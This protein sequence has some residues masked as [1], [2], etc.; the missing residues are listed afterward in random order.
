[1]PRQ[2]DFQALFE[3]LK[4]ILEPYA[5]HL[6]VKSDQPGEYALYTHHKR[7]DGYQFAFGSVQVKKNYVS[8]HLIPLYNHPELLEKISPALRK[9]MQGKSCFNF[10]AADPALL[11]ELSQLTQR[12]FE[13][14]KATGWVS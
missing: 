12:G 2:S 7:P 5:P 14:F 9:R 11:E 1:M 6:E 8:Y 10:K 13:R 4:A 3:R